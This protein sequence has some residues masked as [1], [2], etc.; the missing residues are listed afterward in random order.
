MKRNCHNLIA[1]V[2]SFLHTVSVVSINIQ[3]QNSFVVIQKTHA[4]QYQII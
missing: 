2:K 3:V 1:G 4:R